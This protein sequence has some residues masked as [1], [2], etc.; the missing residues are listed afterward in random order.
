MKFLWLIA[1]LFA[2]HAHAYSPDELRGDC[3]AAEETY[4]GKKSSDPIHAIRSARCI[5]YVAGFADG[6]AVSDFLAD[7]VAVKL[8]AFCLPN[9]PDLS[10]RLVRAVTIHV[11]RVPP[12]TTMSTATLVAGA[13]AK[14]FPCT[15]ALEPKK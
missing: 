3:Q 2:A 12:N 6:Y 14:A 4:A 10:M 15:E 9:D 5:A 13:L 1:V 11:E 8:N 7:K